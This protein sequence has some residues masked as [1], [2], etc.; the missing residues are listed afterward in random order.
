[1]YNDKR[2]IS[3]MDKRVLLLWALLGLSLVGCQDGTDDSQGVLELATRE[4]SEKYYHT[5]EDNWGTLEVSIQL[6]EPTNNEI[7]RRTL[8]REMFGDSIPMSMID[9]LES[10]PPRLFV[11]TL[12]DE[13]GQILDSPSDTI[14][15]KFAYSFEWYYHLSSAY[16][17]ET[18]E[19]ASF[20][21]DRDQYSGGAHG[22]ATRQYLSIDKLTGKVFALSDLFVEDSEE[23]LAQLIVNALMRTHDV[24][25]RQQLE[26]QGFFDLSELTPTENFYITAHG[27]V[28]YYNPYDISAYALGGHEVELEWGLLRRVLRPEGLGAI[29]LTALE[30]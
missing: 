14:G 10:L 9:S 2:I 18:P 15:Y 21:I 12:I 19:V 6:E 23:E 30:D 11:S 5:W 1:M 28:F 7:V 8:T 17:D 27:I 25:S 24:S 26:E 3:V 20:S 22:L 29:Y 13:T 4:R 16:L